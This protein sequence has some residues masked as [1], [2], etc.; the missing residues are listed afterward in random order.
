MPLLH[1]IT[2]VLPYYKT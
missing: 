1:V 2:I